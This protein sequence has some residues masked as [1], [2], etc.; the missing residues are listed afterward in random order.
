MNCGDGSGIIYHHHSLIVHDVF[1][2]PD[3]VYL[4]VQKHDECS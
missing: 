4:S 2:D 1:P 3:I